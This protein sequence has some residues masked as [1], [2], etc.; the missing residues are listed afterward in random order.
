MHKKIILQGRFNFGN[1][2]S[3]GK[4]K[5]LFVYRTENFY[6]NDILLEL[7]DVFK[8]EEMSLDLGRKVINA[9]E[10]S[11]RN[12]IDLLQ[13]CSQF[14]VTGR[15]GGW[16]LDDGKLKKYVDIIPNSE[17]TVVRNYLKGLELIDQKGKEEEAIT[18]LS[19]AIEKYDKHAAAYEKRAYVELQLKKYTDAMRD[20]NKC[21][22]FDD[23]IPEAY[24]GRAK[25]H[26]YRKEFQEAIND[27]ELVTKKAIALQPIYWQARRLKAKYHKQLKQLEKAEFDLR[28]LC[29]RNFQ[30]ENPNFEWKRHDFFTYSQLLFELSK[31]KEALAWLDK[32]LETP[33]GKGK[34]K[35]S[36]ILFYQGIIRKESGK[37]GYL[38]SIKESAAL[39][40]KKAKKYLE[41]RV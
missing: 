22:N 30:K 10:K 23:S 27:L 7:E 13:Y 39:G 38:K 24:Y 14:A 20:F 5:E 17:K 9:M 31:E 26:I 6:R 1:P 25:V 21:I 11:W 37:K 15:V 4:I 16:L 8:D 29:N 35:K 33:E 28:F 32:A 19:S 34:A 41:T 18:A 36:D 2:R 12:T 40:H 3:Y